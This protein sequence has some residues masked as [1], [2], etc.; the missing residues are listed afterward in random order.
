MLGVLSQQPRS[1][2]LLLPLYT[3]MA[4]A[5]QWMPCRKAKIHDPALI[6]NRYH[7]ENAPNYTRA[8]KISSTRIAAKSRTLVLQWRVVP[9][10]RA[11]AVEDMRR[12]WPLL[13]ILYGRN[14]W[15]CS[16][17]SARRSWVYLRH[18]E[19]LT[20]PRILMKL[21]SLDLILASPEFK[22]KPQCCA[23]LS[24]KRP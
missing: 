11:E 9:L 16:G 1:S 18:L 21:L 4:W 14:C 6:K 17:S 23:R 15:M 22:N 7:L 24:A 19:D 5:R 10:A 3:L 2:Q 13:T 8:A 12:Y 20:E